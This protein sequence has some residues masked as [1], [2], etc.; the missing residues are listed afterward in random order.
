MTYNVD[1]TVSHSYGAESNWRTGGELVYRGQKVPFRHNLEMMDTVYRLQT[2][3]ACRVENSLEDRTPELTALMK[4]LDS[5][6]Q[7][8]DYRSRYDPECY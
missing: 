4:E 3:A 6:W 1:G 2:P 7:P 8:A 5:S